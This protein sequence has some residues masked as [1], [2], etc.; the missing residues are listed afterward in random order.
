MKTVGGNRIVPVKRNG[1]R[2]EEIL[3]QRPIERGEFFEDV[4]GQV[5]KVLIPLF[6]VP[7][8]RLSGAVLALADKQ[9]F[10]VIDYGVRVPIEELNFMVRLGK[11]EVSR[12]K[13][14]KFAR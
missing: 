11:V 2:R 1:S 5:F 7:G 6:A 13:A 8:G 10:R 9:T 14:Q 4:E 12:L 3:L